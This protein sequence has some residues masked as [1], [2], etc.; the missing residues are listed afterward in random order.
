[1]GR[2]MGAPTV[3]EKI[4]AA[5][6]GLPDTFTR[7]QLV[8]AAWRLFPDT[9]SLR[10]VDESLPDSNAVYCKLSGVNGLTARGWLEPGEAESVYAV[11]RKGF[12]HAVVLG[13][14]GAAE[15]LRALPVRPALLRVPARP[16]KAKKPP[17]GREGGAPLARPVVKVVPPPAPPVLSPSEAETV[18]L[19]ARTP[20][21]AL[22]A[23][24]GSALS[25]VVAHA[26]WRVGGG[27]EATGALLAR[28]GVEGA[29]VAGGGLPPDPVTVTS[30]AMLHRLLVSRFGGTP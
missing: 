21:V 23:R 20:A 29:T 17:Q 10:G 26:F 25:A 16:R 19:L 14:D 9:F 8:V 4:L 28:A 5:A 27:M 7:A 13:V 30:L 2:V 11:T 18:R 6:A 1:M 22:H 24:G 3:R 12:G 15:R